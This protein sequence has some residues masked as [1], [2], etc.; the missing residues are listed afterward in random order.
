MSPPDQKRFTGYEALSLRFIMTIA[1]LLT[2][3][4]LMWSASAG[5]HGGVPRVLE[6]SPPL[7]PS[8]PFWVIDTLG[9]FR[10]HHDE[11]TSGEM[12]SFA[13]LAPRQW[14]WLCD[15]AV[16]PTLGVDAL[17]V[18][19]ADTLV[20][21]ARSG[22]YRSEDGGCEFKR[23]LSPV[24]EHAIGLLSAH[25]V[26]RSELALF[27]DSFAQE[28]HVWWSADAGATW[29]RSDLTI[30]GSISAMWRDP[31][32]PDEL[33]VSHAEG[34]ARSRDGG[35]TFE[36]LARQDYSVG[37]TPR[38]VKLLGG[39]EVGGR[40]HLWASLNRFPIASLLLSTDEGL[41]WREIHRLN[42]SYDQLVI[43]D[44]ALWVSSPF[45]GLLVYQLG[46]A[47]RMVEEDAWSGL[48]RQ[49]REVFVSCLTPDPQDPHAVWACGRAAP[50][51][52][53]VAR[54]DD[55]GESWAVLMESYQVA[56]EGTWG[57]EDSSPSLAACST[58]CLAEGCDPSQNISGEVAG[59]ETPPVGLAG[60]ESAGDSEMPISGE[61]P[62]EMT[63]RAAPP[64]DEGCQGLT[65]EASY[66]A[67]DLSL[68]IAM[69]S[70][71][72]M[73]SRRRLS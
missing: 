43:T 10:G 7:S 37:A 71:L 9:L 53:V 25:P 5:A 47:E 21:V 52:W 72:L 2:A 6:L 34:L 3:A 15:D 35:R 45:E 61:E 66:D 54:S 12:M 67:R 4:S 49:H 14:S 38:E 40:L 31:T 46:E 57:C 8:D 60:T 69:L 44:E 26:R 33:W 42:D 59:E 41:T 23:V 73:W 39:G 63:E 18:L 48:W 58:R 56:A 64:T 20:A 17:V 32:R 62:G 28:N 22:V 51:G 68:W 16:D 55:L 36:R 24:N 19:D 13:P 70:S 50:T 29:T 27:T 11:M 30:E 65:R 1:H